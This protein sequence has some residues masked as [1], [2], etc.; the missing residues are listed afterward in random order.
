MCQPLKGID[1]AAV[2]E[3]EKSLSELGDKA[4]S[5]AV[6]E[7]QEGKFKHTHP[8]GIDKRQKRHLVHLRFGRAL[9]QHGLE[10][11]DAFSGVLAGIA[12]NIYRVNV[13]AG[14]EVII[15][16]RIGLQVHALMFRRAPESF[17]FK[18]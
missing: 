11:G 13:N 8:A 4:H 16:D 9:R 3:R 7:V 1:H 15:G 5:A 18:I 6:L 10:V 17:H 2:V 12:V 14:L